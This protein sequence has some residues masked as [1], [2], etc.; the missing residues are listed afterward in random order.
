MANYVAEEQKIN[1]V[2]EEILENLKQR[3]IGLCSRLKE[4]K[5]E[6]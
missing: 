1:K 2:V 4:E 3:P 5:N 6:S